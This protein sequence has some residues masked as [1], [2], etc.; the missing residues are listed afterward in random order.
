MSIKY[1][2]EIYNLNEQPNSCFY[3]GIPSTDVEYSLIGCDCCDRYGIRYCGNHKNWAMRD[4]RAHFH[5]EKMID[6]GD[7]SQIEILHEFFTILA[8]S[9]VI[10]VQKYI[11]GGQYIIKKFNFYMNPG[12]VS[13]EQKV[14]IVSP[15]CGYMPSYLNDDWQI[16]LFK[17][18]KDSTFSKKNVS[19][20]ELEDPSV[21]S[22][23]NS[24]IPILLPQVREILDEG[25]YQKEY[26]EYMSL[27]SD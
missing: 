9:K 2:S 14:P 24:R 16:S 5:Q 4:I 19:F 23:N 21:V 26:D 10:H 1:T 27:Q 3:C 13:E 18:E 22:K 20:Y 8:E 6:L 7:V 17:L 15:S 25:I 12:K 11:G